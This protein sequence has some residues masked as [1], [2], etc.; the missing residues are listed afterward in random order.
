M[1]HTILGIDLGTYSIKIAHVEAGFRKTR[2]LALHERPLPSP[3]DGDAPAGGSSEGAASAA[4]EVEPLLSRQVRALKAL[5]DEQGLRPEMAAAAL[6]EETTLRVVSVPLS[7]PKKIEQVLPFELEGQLLG[8]VADHVVSYTLAQTGLQV[9][10]SAGGAKV[11]VAAAPQQAVRAALNALEQVGLEPRLLGAAALSCAPLLLPIQGSADPWPS[12]V[13]VLDLGHTNTQ[14]CVV[15]RQADGEVAATFARTIA[16]G[17]LHL[18]QAL[19]RALRIDLAEAERRKHAADL[20]VP[21]QAAEVLRQHLRPLIRDLRQ[22]LASHTSLY[23][24]APR[25]ILI[26]GGGARLHGLALFLQEALELPVSTLPIPQALVRE[27]AV[28]SE[29]E[30]AAAPSCATALGLALALTGPA[31]QVNFRKGEFAY[32]T[33]YSFLRERAPHL[34]LLVLAVLLSAGLSALAS[35][36]GLQRESEQLLA[37]LTAES[38]SLFGEPM[39]DGEAVSAELNSVL[40]RGGGQ[41]IPTTSAL[42]LLEDISRAAPVV[43][44]KKAPGLDITELNIRPKKTDLKGTAGS[45]QYVDDLA[46]ALTKIPC[47]KDVEKGKVVSVRN[48][49]P[50]GKPVDVRQ[51]SINITTTCP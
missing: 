7:D 3:V 10:G 43:A 9:E 33:D 50:D 31:P 22:T 5:V 45:A 47:F 29:I 39:T 51:F 38:K 18:T 23:G 30:A 32:R 37:S 36:R 40:A 48:N 41:A 1:A 17:G 11:V 15:R 44:D 2:L 20:G 49:G 27:A 42:D 13:V 8:E 12:P 19:A 21:D 28:V 16:R 25:Q 26:T 24:E 4:G 34:A 14:L 35:L 6:S 46:A